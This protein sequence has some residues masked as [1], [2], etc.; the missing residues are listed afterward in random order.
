MKTY[1]GCFMGTDAVDVVLHHLLDDNIN[2]HRDISREKAV[3]VRNTESLSK[4]LFCL[5]CFV[6]QSF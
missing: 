1:E 6:I 4:N 3:K 2:F 5:Y